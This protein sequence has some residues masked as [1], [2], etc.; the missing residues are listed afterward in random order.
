VEQKQDFM[1][2]QEELEYKTEMKFGVVFLTKIKMGF[3]CQMKNI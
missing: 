1:I 3:L 2:V